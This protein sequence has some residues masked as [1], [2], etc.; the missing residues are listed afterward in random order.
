MDKIDAKILSE[1]CSKY[2]EQIE[3]LLSVE[4]SR[5]KSIN[6]AWDQE[7]TD[8]YSGKTKKFKSKEKLDTHYYVYMVE[9]LDSVE[10]DN[11]DLYRICINAL[12]KILK[13]KGSYSKKAG[14]IVHADDRYS[15]IEYYVNYVFA[16]KT[17]D[18]CKA[19]LGS[20]KIK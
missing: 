15:N 1:I 20:C 4:P 18:V 12:N 13:S 7:I 5:L 2:K 14:L 16:N 8:F 11:P 6:N 3:L 17:L 19:I 10:K 9:L